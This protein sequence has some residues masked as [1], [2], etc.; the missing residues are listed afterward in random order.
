MLAG[1]LAASKVATIGE[2]EDEVPVSETRDA[3]WAEAD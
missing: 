2:G 3:G 1:V